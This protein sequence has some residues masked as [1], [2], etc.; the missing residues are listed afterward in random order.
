[1]KI[2]L[3]SLVLCVLMISSAI[4]VGCSSKDDEFDINPEETAPRTPVSLNFWIITDKKTTPDAQTAVEKAFNDIVKSRFT[5]Y[6]DLVFLTRMSIKL[7]S[8]TK[9]KK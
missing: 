2:R 4:L 5:T 3:I 7:L 1:M 9:W 8:Q 6:V